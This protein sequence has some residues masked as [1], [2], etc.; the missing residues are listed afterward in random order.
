MDPRCVHSVVGVVLARGARQATTLRRLLGQDGE[1]QGRVD[2]RL[3]GA[4]SLHERRSEE[5]TPLQ[6]GDL[7]TW[8]AGLERAADDGGLD[9]Q[10]RPHRRDL[11]P[12]RDFATHQDVDQPGRITPANLDRG[13]LDER[14][15]AALT[16]PHPWAYVVDA[17]ASDTL[18]LLA[19]LDRFTRREGVDFAPKLV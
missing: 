11:V 7:R 19:E 4:K 5:V 12:P 17:E 6:G 1:R 9:A 10:L 18:R 15:H 8:L 13:Q 3:D 2:R 14:R 16:S